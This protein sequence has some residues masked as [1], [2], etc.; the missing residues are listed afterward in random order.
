MRMAHIKNGVVENISNAPS[1]EW[2]DLHGGLNVEGIDVHIDD[3]YNAQSKKFTRRVIPQTEK[4]EQ[5]K[6]TIEAVERASMMP[7]AVRELL[8]NVATNKSQTP[9]YKAIKL[10]DDEIVLLRGKIIP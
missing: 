10:V 6:Q 2:I 7:R 5:A 3:D 1:Q 8:L 4:N 9:N